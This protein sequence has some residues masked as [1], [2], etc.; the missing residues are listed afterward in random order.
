MMDDAVR[1]WGGADDTRF[2]IGN[3]EGTERT[4]IPALVG[5]GLPQHRQVGV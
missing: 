5:N 1:K 3:H 4:R 2:W